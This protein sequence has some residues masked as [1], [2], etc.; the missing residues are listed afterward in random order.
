LMPLVRD[1]RHDELPHD[2]GVVHDEDPGHA[3]APASAVWAAPLRAGGA[4]WRKGA[5]MAVSG[6]RVLELATGEQ[7]SEEDLGGWQVHAEETGFADAVGEDE[8]ECL[9]LVRRFLSFMPSHAGQAPP[10][11]AVPAGSGAE[12]AGIAELVAEA[13]TRA[14][15]MTKVLRRM[16]DGGEVFPIRSCRTGAP[17]RCASP[18][19]SG[20]IRPASRPSAASASATS[21]R[22][23]SS[24]RR[25]GSTASRSRRW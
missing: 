10:R 24:T 1:E 5:S 12:M 25:R 15:D 8:A 2:G 13:R 20:S 17:R 16:A 22:S 18:P 3:L 14:Y 11:A 9:D 23:R 19:S 21:A 4:S 7:V 6:P